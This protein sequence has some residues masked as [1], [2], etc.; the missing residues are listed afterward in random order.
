MKARASKCQNT[1]KN[2]LRFIRFRYIAP[3]CGGTE[4]KPTLDHCGDNRALFGKKTR[5]IEDE[6]DDE[7]TRVQTSEFWG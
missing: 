3:D 7:A 2:F 6:N 5:R 4:A 1:P